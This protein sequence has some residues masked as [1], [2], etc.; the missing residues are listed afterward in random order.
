M[1]PVSTFRSVSYQNI[2]EARMQH[3]GSLGLDLRGKTVLELG[4]GIGDITQYLMQMGCSTITRIEAR[5]YNCVI[6][7]QEHPEHP[8]FCDDLMDPKSLGTTF[9]LC[10]A[11]GILYHLADPTMA[12]RFMEKHTNFA[13]V[14]TC[15]SLGPGDELNPVDEGSHCPSQATHGKGSRPTRRWMLASLRTAFRYV[16][17]PVT[18]PNHVQFQLDWLAHPRSTL[19]RAIF[20]CSQTPIQNPLLVDHLPDKHV[21]ATT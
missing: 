1:D 14:E 15:V 9:G 8:V 21:L 4:A 12:I 19:T 11:Y 16:Y 13:I 3:L 10:I 2:N 5:Q 20:V 17:C 6:M 7:R 18:Q